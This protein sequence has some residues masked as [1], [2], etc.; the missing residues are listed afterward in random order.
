MAL[1]IMICLLKLFKAKED[2]HMA[3][4]YAFFPRVMNEINHSM[5]VNMDGGE[6]IPN[7]PHLVNLVVWYESRD[8]GFPLPD[9]FQRI[10][11]I[12]D[13][14][15]ENLMTKGTIHLG[16][17][18]GDGRV[19][20]FFATD[21]VLV[22]NYL[23]D[24]EF[25]YSVRENEADEFYRE[26]LYP[27]AYENQYVMNQ[28]VCYNME[29][30]GELFEKERDVDFYF[31]FES[32]DVAKEFSSHFTEFAHTINIENNED[33]KIQVHMIA[34]IIPSLGFMNGVS[35]SIVG[36]LE[37]YIGIYDGWGSPIEA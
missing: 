23:D 20:H 25:D 13:T 9:E 14:L 4:N 3:N 34:N 11:S 30:S 22:S 31:Y 2:I 8:N 5:R 21:D 6:Y 1:C 7:H 35:D 32:E 17:I 28:R 18:T 12:E 26:V 29:Q 36:L 33:N 19:R 27:D 24:L 37:T 16:A 10:N 15:I